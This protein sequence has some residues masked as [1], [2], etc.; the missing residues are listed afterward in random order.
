[1]LTRYYFTDS[2]R[3][4]RALTGVASRFSDRSEPAPEKIRDEGAG[5][6][7]RALARLIVAIA[8]VVSGPPATSPPDRW[9]DWAR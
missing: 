8:D 9:G 2:E 3:A 1:M 7:G 6:Y 5:P 4:A